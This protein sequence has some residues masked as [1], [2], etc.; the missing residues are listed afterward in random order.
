MSDD[1]T[2]SDYT[3]AD[4]NGARKL[5][6][7]VARRLAGLDDDVVVVGGIVPTLLVEIPKPDSGIKPHLGTKDV[8]LGLAL[9]LVDEE[10]HDEVAGRLRLAGFKRDTNES[11]NL[12]PQRWILPGIQGVSLDFLVQPK[13]GGRRPKPVRQFGA[14]FGAYQIPGLQLAFEDLR[15]VFVGDGAPADKTTDTIQICDAGAFVVLKALAIRHRDKAKDAYDL[16]WVLHAYAGGVNEV[17]ARIR[18]LSDCDAKREALE[19]LQLEYASVDS[20]GPVRTARFLGDVTNEE[21]R[22]DAFARTQELLRIL[23]EA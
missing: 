19:I 20:L 5:C 8:D 12:T 10:R 15:R 6:L 2:H 17:A 18:K 23:G 21:I 22:A 13:K 16:D 3:E 11:G 14:D 9:R 1:R 7:L 4:L